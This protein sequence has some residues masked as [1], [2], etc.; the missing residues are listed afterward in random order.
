MLLLDKGKQ[1]R[2]QILQVFLE[3]DTPTVEIRRIAE[4][5]KVSDYLVK[6]HLKRLKEDLADYPEVGIQFEVDEEKKE[7]LIQRV[8]P[9]EVFE[10]SNIYLKNSEEFQLFYH[11]LTD[12]GQPLKHY[13]QALFLSTSKVYKI[14]QDLQTRLKPYELVID[15]ENRLAG[16]ELTVRKNL[17]TFYLKKFHSLAFPFSKKLRHD[18]RVL[19][20]YIE[21]EL[22]HPLSEIERIKLIYLMSVQY[23][24]IKSGAVIQ[25][26]K[27]FIE[28]KSDDPIL[29]LIQWF[30]V[31]IGC[32]A[33][34]IYKESAYVYM[35]LAVEKFFPVD[36]SRIH[37]PDVFEE[38]SDEL[39]AWVD[40]ISTV[41]IIAETRMILFHESMLINYKYLTYYS[42]IVDDYR[43]AFLLNY[44]RSYPHLFFTVKEYLYNHS[45]Q[46]V[47]KFRD[48]LLM[49]Y[50]FIFTKYLPPTAYEDTVHV[51]IDFSMGEQFNDYIARSLQSMDN[52]T[53]QV[54]RGADQPCDI[55]LSD[56][57]PLGA[58]DHAILWSGPPNEKDWSFLMDTIAAVKKEKYLASK[59]DS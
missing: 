56:F 18:L 57:S 31:T 45:S 30:L 35:F 52:M 24:R 44:E 4:Q 40:E 53:I 9:D 27:S 26:F 54:T 39:L 17:F 5:L 59:T 34:L 37:F 6:Q 43:D 13:G 14:K 49:E 33:H 20:H 7:V 16:D 2:F 50:I 41:P 38:K 8:M 51:T 29:L 22:G 23:Y 28:V 47:W 10:L 3:S 1:L 25:H 15:T 21:V 11:L 12:P 46:R 32:P 42:K 19:V 55:Y 36:H 48:Q 58:R